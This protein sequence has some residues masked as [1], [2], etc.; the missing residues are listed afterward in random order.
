MPPVIIA[1][2]VTYG[3]TAVGVT[4]VVAGISVASVI[5]GAAAFAYSS[6]VA[7]SQAN[8]ARAAA[9]AQ[10]A[11]AQSAQRAQFNA[12][13]RDVTMV[14]DNPVMPRRVIFGETRVSGPLWPWFTH[15]NIGQYHT[16]AVTLAAHE[17]QS[18]E[19]IYFNE[20]EVTLNGSGQVIAPAK[21]VK[22]DTGTPLFTVK[23]YLGVPGQ[24]AAPELVSAASASGNPAAWTAASKGAGLCY[25]TVQMT[26]DFDVLGDIGVPSVSAIVRGVKALDPRTGLTTWTQ[27]PALLARWF[28]LDCPY[29]PA[30]LATEINN[31][32]LVASANVCDELINFSATRNE[33]RYTCNGTIS[34]ADLPIANLNHIN[35]SMDGDA[36][37]ISGQWQILAGYYKTPTLALT[38]DD[39]S[40]SSIM[41]APYI[42]KADLYNTVTGTHF[43]ASNNYT[44]P[45]SYADVSS[46]VYVAE[47]GGEVLPMGNDFALVDDGVR[48]QMLAWQRLSRARNGA[49]ISL[50]TNM[51]GYDSTPGRNVTILARELL[52]DLPKTYMV[53]RRTFDAPRLTYLLQETGPEVW[54]WDYSQSKASVNIPNT[55][56]PDAFAIPVPGSPVVVESLYVTAGSAGVKNRASVSWMAVTNVLVSGYLLEHKISTDTVWVEAPPTTVNSAVI[57]DLA[58]GVY[59]FRVRCVTGTGRRG[60]YSAAT[61]K[62]MF[63]LTAKPANT[64]NFNVIK[65]S[66][67]AFA[68]WNITP[69]LDVKV[70]GRL[71]IRH[72]PASTGASWEQGIV[73]EEFNGDAVS[74]TVPLMQGT[75]MAKF[76][77]STGNY[78]STAALFV[79]TE[80]LVTGFTTVGTIAYNPDFAGAYINSGVVDSRLQLVSQELFDS[81]ELFDSDSDMDGGAISAAGQADFT[82]YLDLT[83]NAIRRIQ[84]TVTAVSFD[85]VD[86]F[87]SA[88]IFDSSE[89]FDGAAVNDCDATIY[90]ATTPDNPAASPVWSVWQP[91]FVG[92][93]GGRAY[94]FRLGLSSGLPSH[95]IAVS[96][97]S[98]T[99]KI[100]T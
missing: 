22:T 48:C 47:D 73:L 41:I 56:F 97:F 17:C 14:I 13:L 43:S 87:D 54:A 11:Q 7:S 9:D 83:T 5:G 38:E 34:C 91:F 20:D 35:D 16:F 81:A 93:F 52:G 25:L 62:E 55:S 31:T 61:T 63:G 8:A 57:D 30:T 80:G 66:G 75:Y 10:S 19:K 15:G 39:L 100:P 78:S 59:S 12:S 44:S 23:K 58:P 92:D 64:E 29:S 67:L 49:T 90:I 32:E 70:N 85:V 18:V 2:V 40:E 36:V 3:A 1:A 98:V 27:N 99:A 68:T 76:R 77:D 82:N 26:A 89:D 95:N 37:Y 71:V 46:A 50:G 65:S 42:P 33:K 84:A 69:D 96:A 45:I 60:V 24:A 51:R 28:M 94:R 88:E 53:M 74:G 72:T 21:Y 86:F 4:A 6:S 79:A